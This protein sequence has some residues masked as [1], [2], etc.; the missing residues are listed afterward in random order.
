MY[1]VRATLY[2][3][4]MTT[5][6]AKPR[7]SQKTF[8]RRTI[9]LLNDSLNDIAHDISIFFQINLPPNYTASDKAFDHIGDQG[10]Y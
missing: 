10:G 1:D 4:D 5:D 7:S 8:I 9:D 3:S 2:P 6:I